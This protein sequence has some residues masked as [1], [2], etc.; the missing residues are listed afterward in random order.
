[1][2]YERLKRTKMEEVRA[3]I[4]EIDYDY[5]VG[6]DAMMGR[7]SDAEAKREYL[8]L[9][10]TLPEIPGITS[11]DIKVLTTEITNKINKLGVYIHPDY[12]DEV[13]L[14]EEDFRKAIDKV[15]YEHRHSAGA[16][17]G[18]LSVGEATKDYNTV[19]EVLMNSNLPEE[20]K[21]TLRKEIVTKIGQIPKVEEEK[22]EERRLYEAE[23]DNAFNSAKTRFKELSVFKRVKLR[24]EGKAPHQLDREFMDTEDY[25]NLYRK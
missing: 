15:H 17:F 18:P 9:L 21:N 13:L 1:M 14:T 20:V 10:K 3:A 4:E 16:M 25:N 12:N 6:I 24:L 8:E 5:K 19:L 23:L 11:E 2:S 7:L 22:A